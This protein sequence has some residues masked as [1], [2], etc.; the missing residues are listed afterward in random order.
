MFSYQFSVSDDRE[1]VSF[2]MKKNA[3]L[4]KKIK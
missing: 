1:L 3:I 2:V 4:Q